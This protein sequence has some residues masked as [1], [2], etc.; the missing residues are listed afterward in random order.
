MG[1]M[2]CLIFTALGTVTFIIPN[3][4]VPLYFGC[5]ITSL[6]HPFVREAFNK[7]TDV[8]RSKCWIFDLIAF[9]SGVVVFAAFITNRNLPLN[10][11]W[12]KLVLP[13][14]LFFICMP[15][16]QSDKIH[17][18]RLGGLFILLTAA[19]SYWNPQAK[20]LIFVPLMVETSLLV[21]EGMKSLRDTLG[22]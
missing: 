3:F 7:D 19:A 5:L 11:L 22:I 8:I 12:P 6:G 20:P 4:L 16:A 14:A 18:R 15:F 1:I 13:L 10:E 21:I 17:V 9:F 2:F